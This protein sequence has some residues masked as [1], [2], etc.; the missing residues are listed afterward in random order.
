MSWS[1]WGNNKNG[2]RITTEEHSGYTMNS[3]DVY[4]D[5]KNYWVNEIVDAD[6]TVRGTRRDRDTGELTEYI[7][8]K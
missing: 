5:G 7:Y 8:R 4:I 1:I 3:G 6:G 2:G